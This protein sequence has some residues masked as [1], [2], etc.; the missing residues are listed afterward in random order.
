MPDL[1]KRSYQKELLDEDGI[2]FPAIRQNMQELNTINRLLGGHRITV[3]GI[4]ALFDDKKSNNVICEIGC[5][6]GDNLAAI[7]R[8]CRKKNIRVRYMGVDIK[9]ECVDFAQQQYPQLPVEWIVSDY[10]DVDF[11]G[12][13]P[14]IIF[15]SLFCHH[16][17]EDQLVKMLQ[18]MND[19]CT[20]GF[21]INDLHRHPLAYY[22]IKL[23]T[24]LFSRSYLV[25]NDAP[26]SVTRGFT[27]KEWKVLLQKAGIARYS[28]HWKWAF[29]HLLVC[30]K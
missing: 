11:G 23:L 5:G 22:S 9:Q 19:H 21:F 8:W 15:S 2:P 29:R 24:A 27:K 20:T 1:R 30:K 4:K 16:F 18:W 12:R 13:Q 14:G 17:T 7:D 28:L 26:L 25:K 10:A 3:T 6:G